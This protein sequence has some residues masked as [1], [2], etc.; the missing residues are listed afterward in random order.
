[1]AVNVSIATGKV[2]IECRFF[3]NR[4]LLH[5]ESLLLDLKKFV[6]V[7]VYLGSF[8]DYTK[9]VALTI[10]RNRDNRLTTTAYSYNIVY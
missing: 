1:M 7:L 8:V 6:S 4:L 5:L 2:A 3:A 9:H 10:R